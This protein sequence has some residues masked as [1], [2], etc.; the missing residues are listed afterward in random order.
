MITKEQRHLIAREMIAAGKTNSAK[1]NDV[2][3]A[4][5]RCGFRLVAVAP[6]PRPPEYEEVKVV[7]RYGFTEIRLVPVA[8]PDTVP[9]TEFLHR[10][11]IEELWDTGYWG[12]GP[13]G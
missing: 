5:E 2:L 13:R 12:K 8:L 1:I 7:G 6:P 10:R 11:S 4:M 3:E 9:S